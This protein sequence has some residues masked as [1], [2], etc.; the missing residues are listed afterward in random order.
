MTAHALELRTERQVDGWLGLV[1]DGG[2]A[3]TLVIGRIIAFDG[4]SPR[5]IRRDERAL[6]RVGVCASRKEVPP[7]LHEQGPSGRAAKGKASE[8]AA[9]LE[10]MGMSTWNE[11][12]G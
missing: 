5:L 2:T 7:A 12:V 11:H 6:C 8:A 3:L 1:E 9:G 4:T 10:G